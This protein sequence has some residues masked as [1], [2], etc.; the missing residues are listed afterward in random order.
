MYL[1]E[2]LEADRQHAEEARHKERRR[3]RILES[4]DDSFAL[5]KQQEHALAVQK[6]LWQRLHHAGFQSQNNQSNALFQA[7]YF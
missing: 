6:G 4:E 5:W 2:R 1:I 3:R 7:L